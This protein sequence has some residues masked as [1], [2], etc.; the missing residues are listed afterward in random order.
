MTSSLAKSNRTAMSVPRLMNTRCPVETYLAS[1][2]S[3]SRTWPPRRQRHRGHGVEMDIEP[4]RVAE[5][6]HEADG[7][8]PGLPLRCRNT[9]PSADRGKDGAHKY[10]QNVP[11]QG[12][13]ERKPIAEREGH[14]DMRNK[15]RPAF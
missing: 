1:A 12:R 15:E 5:A 9:R 10:L 7:A 3:F 6:L 2:A 13:G 11:D 14:A 8:A 4:E